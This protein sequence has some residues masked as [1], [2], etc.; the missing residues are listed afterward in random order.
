MI[1]DQIMEKCVMRRLRDKLLQ[2]NGLSVDK[3]LSTARAFEAAQAES[4]I[5]TEHTSHR[6]GDDRINLTKSGRT[7]HR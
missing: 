7:D 3:A 6:M 1:R 4:K 2:E 5:F